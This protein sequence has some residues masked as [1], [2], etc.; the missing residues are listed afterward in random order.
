MPCERPAAQRL[1]AEAAAVGLAAAALPR[2]PQ[3]ETYH[4]FAGDHRTLLGLPHAPNVLSNLAIAVP[5]IVGLWRLWHLRRRL[6]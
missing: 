5:G 4:K 3:P 6:R 2:I 1:A